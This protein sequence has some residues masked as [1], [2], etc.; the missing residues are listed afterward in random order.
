MPE[1]V[2]QM[3]DLDHAQLIQE[4]LEPF[5][6]LGHQILVHIRMIHHLRVEALKTQEDLQAEVNHLQE[7]IAE[8]TFQKGYELY[9]DRIAAKFPK[10]DLNFL[11]REEPA[12]ATSQS[13]TAVDPSPIEVVFESSDPTVEVPELICLTS[14]FIGMVIGGVSPK[15]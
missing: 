11:Y 2:D 9:E 8:E 3:A 1:V 7:K 5:L 15:I 6:K 10:L 12:E 4:S 14:S 13:T